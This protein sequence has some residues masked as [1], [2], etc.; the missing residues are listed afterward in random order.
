[1]TITKGRTLEYIEQEWG[2]YIE[3]FQR[4]SKEEQEKRVKEQGY[5][6]FRDM[7]AHILAWWEEGMII[8]SAIAENRPFER[9]EYDFNAFN[10]EAIAKY[11]DWDEAE[12]LAHFEKTRQK[13]GTDLRSMNEAVFENRRVQAWVNGIIF[14]HAR[15]HLVA[16]SRFLAIDL[17]ENEWAE[18]VSFFNKLSDEKKKEFL[19]RQGFENFHDLLAHVIGWWEEG[20]RIISGI[21]DSPSFTWEARDTDSF[22]VELTQKYSSWSD[23]DLFTHY[24]AVRVAMIDLVAE[25]PDD[26]FLNADIEGW[27][28][29][30]VVGHYDDHPIPH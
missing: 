7:L 12:F 27:L 18:Y 28:K 29:D 20:A 25:L 22:N 5:E 3:R 15:E 23:R 30:D 11:K 6:R 9:K 16:L 8:I 2:T 24:E 1:M 13:M 21:T 4:L 17:L 10:A 26:A 14:H 19:S